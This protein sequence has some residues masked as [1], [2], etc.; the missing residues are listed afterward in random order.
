MVQFAAVGRN[1]TFVGEFAQH[2]LERSAAIVLQVEGARNLADADLAGAVADEREEFFL[3]GEG[4]R[5]GTLLS[6]NL[7]AAGAC[8]LSGM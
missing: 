7:C 4:D 1:V 2:A 5:Q 6:Q 8:L 3:V